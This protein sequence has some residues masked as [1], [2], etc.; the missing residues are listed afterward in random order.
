MTRR[1]DSDFDHFKALLLEQKARLEKELEGV[2]E[3]TRELDEAADTADDT[4]DVSVLDA[5]NAVDQTQIRRIRAEL[6][7]VEAALKRIEEGTYGICEKIGK[8]IPVE[9]LE[10][11]PAARTLVE[12]E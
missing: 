3:E 12:T 6:D 7:E 4:G 2:D 9:R 5:Q 1:E 11:N 10:A 8:P